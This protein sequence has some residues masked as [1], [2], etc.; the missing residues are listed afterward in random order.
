MKYESEQHNAK[1]TKSDSSERSYY[2]DRLYAILQCGTETHDNYVYPQHSDNLPEYARR[3][4][5]AR[6]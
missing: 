4:E 3:M 5:R 2:Q 6:L 1:I